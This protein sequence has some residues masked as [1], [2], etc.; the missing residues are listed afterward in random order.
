MARI[1]RR[2]CSLFI[3]NS[4]C[5]TQHRIYTDTYTH[6]HSSVVMMIATASSDDE[7]RPNQRLDGFSWLDRTLR[8]VSSHFQTAQRE[9]LVCTVFSRNIPNRGQSVGKIGHPY[10]IESSRCDFGDR[11]TTTFDRQRGARRWR[12]PKG[13]VTPTIMTM[14]T[15]SSSPSSSSSPKDYIHARS[16]AKDDD[17]YATTLDGKPYFPLLM[18]NP[19]DEVSI[20]AA[21]TKV[22]GID[23]DDEDGVALSVTRI[24]G[25]LTNHLFRVSGLPT[26]GCESVLVRVFGAEGMIDR[27]VE[28]PAFAAL[29]RAGIAP[30]YHGRFGNGRVEGWIEARPL[31]VREFS[32]LEYSVK[33]AQQMSK[34]HNS[35][36]IPSALQEYFSEPTLWKQ[37]FEWMDEALKATF[38]TDRDTTMAEELDLPNI[39]EQLEWLRKEVV[40]ADSSVAFCHNDVLAANVLLE[41]GTV[42]LHLIDFEYGGINFAAFDIANHFMEFA[43]GTDIPSG[44]PN[45][46]WLPTKE[47]ERAF[48][49]SYLGVNTDGN[50]GSGKADGEDDKTKDDDDDDKDGKVD[51]F[52]AEVQ[53][54]KLVNHLYW[55][56][57]AVNQAATEGCEEFDYMMYSTK[58]IG[59]YRHDKAEL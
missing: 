38:K 56:L 4:R 35:F 23:D 21:A 2:Y 58:R 36:Q 47:L 39:R 22:M 54:F 14:T 44:I 9:L 57:W 30:P 53:A 16:E 27:D 29:A 3:I 13:T 49:E 24:Q 5:Y 34:L 48:V 41:E 50:T 26:S 59:Q 8:G 55:G 40:P 20:R 52:L 32:V 18:V 37:L 31:K 12:D 33:I 43:G 28:N 19:S 7:G 11:S 45:Y 17:K 25:G 51:S 6:T 1:M 42:Q 46:D 10:K 15:M